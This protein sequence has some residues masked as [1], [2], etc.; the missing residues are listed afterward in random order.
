VIDRL[1]RNRMNLGG[2]ILAV[3]AVIG[4]SS[5]LA[6]ALTR[7][8]GGVT[9]IW[10]ASGL[11]VGI[12]LTAA[13]DRWIGYIIAALVGN[14]V[15]RI[16]WGDPLS[17]VVIR[18]FASTFEACLVAYSLRHWVGEV[19][20]PAKLPLVSRVASWSTAVACALSALMVATLA[21]ARGTGLLGATFTSWFTSHLLGIFIVATAFVVLRHRGRLLFIRP[22]LRWNFALTISL[23]VATTLLVFSQSHYPLLFLVY[24][25]LVFAAFRHRFEGFAA[26]IV[27]VVIIS[28]A[29]TVLGSGPLYLVTGA[30]A[31]DRIVLLQ[32]FLTTACLSTLPIVVI[33]SQ[34]T[35]L[36]RALS[37]GERRLRAITDSLPAAVAHFDLQQRY[38]FANAFSGNTYGSN[39]ASIIGRT[40]R[41]VRGEKVYAT[42]KPYVDAALRGERVTFEGEVA[43]NGRHYHYQS[44]FIPDVGAE[45]AVRGFYAMTSDV[46]ERFLAQAELERIA[47]HDSLTGLGNRNRFNDHFGRALARY[48]RNGR[49]TALVYLDIDYFKQI[50]D[51]F[52][53]AV[54]DAVLCEFAKRLRTNIRETDLAVRL[55]G[56]EFAVIIEDIESV[57][58]LD[59]VGRKLIA[60][61]Q[62]NIVVNRIT[63]QVTASIGIAVCGPAATAESLM[64]AADQ[65]LYAAKAAGRNTFRLATV[66]KKE[67]MEVECVP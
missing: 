6:I 60:V 59:V 21:S 56:D 43:T 36:E 24:P 14:L 31:Q 35:R 62:Q 15:A 12:L 38:T 67:P 48:R 22:T 26:G 2:C 4:A 33:L 52:G 8:A 66:E 63:I 42:I 30:S 53:H 51:T 54:G 47:Q 55:G 39:C 32:L 20:D 34:R 45:G 57:D 65:A 29:A 17:D 46:S 23:A 3:A 16:A 9:I 61:M 19:S 28:L 10:V 5:W 27:V 49:P 41:E 13:H 50:N 58:A 40:L 11:L 1:A 25:A 37:D 44:E 7:P 64:L 18:G